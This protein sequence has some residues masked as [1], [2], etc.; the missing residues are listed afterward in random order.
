MTSHQ[1]NVRYNVKRFAAVDDLTHKMKGGVDDLHSPF[2]FTIKE[3]L[4]GSFWS[5][6]ACTRS[7]VTSPPWPP[8]SPESAE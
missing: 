3:E 2:L 1:K 5:I 6:V 8:A 4:N 7:S